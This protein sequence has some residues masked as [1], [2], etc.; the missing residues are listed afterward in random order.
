MKGMPKTNFA[1]GNSRERSSAY[2]EEYIL[3]PKSLLK[4]KPFL[5]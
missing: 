2:R 4:S 1:F 5:R 3:G